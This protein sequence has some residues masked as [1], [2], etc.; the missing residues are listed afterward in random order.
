VG[1]QRHPLLLH[2]GANKFYVGPDNGLFTQVL[3]HEGLQS[4]YV[5]QQ[6]AYFRAPD[7]SLTFHG[8]DIFGPVAAHLSLGVPPASFGPRRT[9]VITLP[10]P[11]L[12]VTGRTITGEILH[13][14]HFGNILTNI[15]PDLLEQ[16]RPGAYL[17]VTLRHRTERL[18]FCATYAE[19]QQERLIC[20]IS[21]NA[22]VEVACVQGSA[23]AYFSA[24]VGDGIALC[25]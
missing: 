16:V 7:I 22:E 20:L 12:Q 11:Q 8:R 3:A 1:S 6:R 10:T 21:S 14:D 13:I 17:S 18:P 23:A 19:A 4:A 5:L 15:T 24:E 25:Y 9:E 2:T